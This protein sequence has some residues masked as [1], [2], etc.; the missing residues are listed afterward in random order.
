MHR[1]Y[2]MN[3][4]N[5]KY[6]KALQTRKEKQLK[7]GEKDATAGN[8]PTMDELAYI[9]G[10][11]KGLRHVQ[12]VKIT[13]SKRELERKENVV[14]KAIE[15]LFDTRN[16]IRSIDQEIAI[17]RELV[18]K[19]SDFNKAMSKLKIFGKYTKA[20]L[21]TCNCY[22]TYEKAKGCGKICDDALIK[23]KH[24]QEA[25]LSKMR[26]EEVV[27]V[28]WDTCVACYLYEFIMWYLPPPFYGSIESTLLDL[29]CTCETVI[30]RGVVMEVCQQVVT[31]IFKATI[32]E[33]IAVW[34]SR[35]AS[36]QLYPIF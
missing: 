19:Q 7:H 28:F 23:C 8:P 24:L 35:M 31:L 12:N 30:D 34:E 4:D 17:Q 6:I 36:G 1:S 18:E 15:N 2:C 22:L 5:H 11:E 13:P 16:Q 3:K 25:G 26:I 10:Y 27:H 29:C 9:Q 14:T 21:D 32:I 20:Y 33:T